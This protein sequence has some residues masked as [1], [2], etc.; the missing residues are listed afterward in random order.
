MAKMEKFRRFYNNRFS[1]RTLLWKT[2]LGNEEL[3]G[4]LGESKEKH[5]LIVSTYQMAFLMLFNQRETYRYD[6]ICN[7]LN[8]A[9]PDFE[10]HILGI[11][12]SGIMCKNT[13]EKKIEANTEFFLNPEFKYKMFRLKIPVLLP[14]NPI[15]ENLEQEIPEI[16]EDDRKHMIEGCIV[17]IMKSRRTITHQNLIF[18]VVKMISWKF[19][20]NSKQIKGRIENLIEREFLQ[21]DPKDANTYLYIV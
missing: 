14:K 18:E 4:F 20:A 8:V 7:I 12:K 11:I 10:H 19:T 3:R 15:E 16:V 13:P 2:N 6:E 5:E 17:K 9:D 21:R 1:G